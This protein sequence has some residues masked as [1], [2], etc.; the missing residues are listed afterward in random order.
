MDISSGKLAK[1]YTRRPGYGYRRET[2]G[3]VQNNAIRTNY[4]RVKIDN[5]QQNSKCRLCG[6]KK[7]KKKK[8]K[9]KRKRLIT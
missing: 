6:D 7:K 9:R 3:G 4:I 2:S 1:S 8:K 5:M